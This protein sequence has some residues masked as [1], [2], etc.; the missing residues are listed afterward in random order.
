MTQRQKK[1]LEDVQKSWKKYCP[2]KIQLTFFN[3]L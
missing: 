1:Q 2:E 3:I